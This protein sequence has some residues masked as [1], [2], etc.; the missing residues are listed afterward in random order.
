[1]SRT[2]D[3]V[4]TADQLALIA[5]WAP[6]LRNAGV[7]Q[8]SCE[9]MT[10]ELYPAA[11]TNSPGSDESSRGAHEES[12]RTDPLDDPATYGGGFVPTY[13]REREVEG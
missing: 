13:E 12:C 9:G 2:G 11:G 7:R 8:F 4:P 1:M 3:N 5:H 10:L 6:I